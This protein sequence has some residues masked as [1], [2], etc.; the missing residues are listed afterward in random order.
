MRGIVKTN[1]SKEEFSMVKTKTNTRQMVLTAILT[2][3]VAVLQLMG[4]FIKFGPFSI[5]LVLLPIV[6]G[7]AE[8]G[9]FS[10]A[11]LGFVFGMVV[12]ISGDAAPF[13]AVDVF[14]TIVTVLLKGTLCGLC[15][16]W[17]YRLISKYN[18]YAAV[19]L[20]AIV[21]PLVNTGIFLLGCLVF[22]MD[23]I[24]VWAGTSSVW[25]YM[26]FVLVGG[27]FLF[28]LGSNALLSPVI[29]RLLN[30]KTR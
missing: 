30:I 3:L 5:S 14:G 6:I 1:D 17:V 22:F 24:R 2:A 8:C 29:V 7:A 26:I 18:R 10:G 4:S 27:N 16:A 20:A 21:C 13:M 15:A 23:T 19:V 12:L 9:I 11:W 28:E 25:Y